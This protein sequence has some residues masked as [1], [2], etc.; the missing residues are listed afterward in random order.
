VHLCSIAKDFIDNLLLVDP[1]ER[2]TA[3][4]ALQHPWLKNGI[5]QD[6][7]LNTVGAKMKEFTHQAKNA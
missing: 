3:E 7:Q 2:F 1:E 5:T 6:K 4:Q